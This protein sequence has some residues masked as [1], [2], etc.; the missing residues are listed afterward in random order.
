[1]NALEGARVP[2]GEHACCSAPDDDALLGLVDVD[3]AGYVAAA[4]EVAP[5][6]LLGLDGEQLV[7]IDAAARA[8]RLECCCRVPPVDRRI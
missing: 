3:V 5:L 1:M 7:A 6:A 4:L 8:R 2:G